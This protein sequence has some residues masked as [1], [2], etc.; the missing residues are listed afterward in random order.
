[1]NEQRTEHKIEGRGQR[2]GAAGNGNGNGDLT[3]RAKIEYV[4]P[5]LLRNDRELDEWWPLEP[6]EEPGEQ[7]FIADIAERGVLCPLMVSPDGRTVWDGRRRLRAAKRFAQQLHQVPV[8]RCR[9]EERTGVILAGLAHHRNM[10]QSAQVYVSRRW[11]KPIAEA[12][13]QMTGGGMRRVVAPLK[14]HIL[15]TVNYHGGSIPP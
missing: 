8:I 2:L 6:I 15:A 5:M 12:P 7:A 9:E 11:W 14:P 3:G 1:M 13:K 4:D 10:S